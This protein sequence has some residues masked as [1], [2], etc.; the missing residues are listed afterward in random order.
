MANNKA[1][2]EALGQQDAR[3][4][5]VTNRPESIGWQRTAYLRAY[6]AETMK[7]FQAKI[8]EAP[9]PTPVAAKKA[10]PILGVSRLAAQYARRANETVRTLAKRQQRRQRRERLLAQSRRER[11]NSADAWRRANILGSTD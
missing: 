4:G 2:Y 8:A 5:V 3:D 1:H 6:D 10:Q 11:A 9:E 7:K